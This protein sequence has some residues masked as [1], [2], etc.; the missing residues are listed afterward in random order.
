MIAILFFAAFVVIGDAFAV[1]IA[2]FFEPISETAS[3]MVFL[4]LFV[5]VFCVAW[6][7]AVHVTERFFVTDPRS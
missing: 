5:G 2:S 3:L 7:L 6:I 4:G 1:L